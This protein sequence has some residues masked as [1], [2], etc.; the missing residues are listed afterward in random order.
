MAGKVEL[1]IASYKFLKQITKCF[2]DQSLMLKIVVFC[3]LRLGT[4]CSVAAPECRLPGM[5][6]PSPWNGNLRK[7]VIQKVSW[8][9]YNGKLSPKF[10]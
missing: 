2:A 5:A 9:F 6:S 4:G 1:S 10:C 7:C 8:Y 3:T